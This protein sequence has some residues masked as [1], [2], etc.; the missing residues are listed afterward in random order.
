MSNELEALLKE[1]RVFNPS[2]EII[3]GSNIKKWM[4]KHNLKDYDELQEKSLE[5]PQ[6]FW[7]EIA[8]ELEWFQLYKKVLKWDPPNVEWF[9]DGKTNIV[10]NALD[11]HIEG[12]HKDKIAF[13]WEGENGEVKKLSYNDLYM[14][15]NR[16]A[17]ALKSLGVEKGDRVS[18][19]LPMILELPIA[20]LA[21][22]KIGA[23]HSV[24]FSGF[25]AKAFADRINDAGSK[26]AI[27]A[28]GFNR[29][30]KSYI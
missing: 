30:G 18:I 29:R 26:I 6:W 2:T 13:I 11:R 12:P 5:N 17:N 9:L 19:Y 27:T 3:E 15:V 23:I 10:H 20:M 1:K 21:C 16:F 7:N 24:V 28:D 4:D 22:A 25:S 8:G 14:E